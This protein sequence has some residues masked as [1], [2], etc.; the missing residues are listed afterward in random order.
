MS[1]SIEATSHF[2]KQLK[3]LIKKFPSLKTEF[4]ELI[5]SLMEDPHQG[6]LWEMTVIK[7]A[8]RLHP[9][10]KGNLVGQEL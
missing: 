4:N 2:D 7:Y 3:R 9:K 10:E 6:L 5:N 8:L 1:Y